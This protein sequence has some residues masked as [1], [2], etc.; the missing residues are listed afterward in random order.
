[1]SL[2]GVR[3]IVP[4]P[5][6]TPIL[7]FAIAILDL[8]DETRALVEE[9]RGSQRMEAIVL[10]LISQ[11]SKS[12]LI[13]SAHSTADVHTFITQHRFAYRTV[14]DVLSLF[15]RRTMLSLRVFGTDCSIVDRAI[16]TLILYLP[17]ESTESFHANTATAIKSDI[18]ELLDF[19]DEEQFAFLELPENRRSRV[20]FYQM[21]GQLISQEQRWHPKL[22]QFSAIVDAKLATLREAP[23]E[24]LAAGLLLDIRGLFLGVTTRYTYEDLFHWFHPGAVELLQ[25]AVLTFPA[26]QPLFLKFL[27][28]FVSNRK[29]RIMFEPHSANGLKMFKA[30]AG[31]LIHFF[32]TIDGASTAADNHRPVTDAIRIMEIIL[33]NQFSCIGA[34]EVYNDTTLT[35]LF[36]EFLRLARESDIA[37]LLAFPKTASALMKL[38]CCLFDL[39][40][41]QVVE[42]D[43]TFVTL[44]LNICAQANTSTGRSDVESSFAVISEITDFC[45]A[46]EGTEI[47]QRLW[48]HTRDVYNRILRMLEEMVFRYTQKIN[49]EVT[50]L[51]AS[52]LRMRPAAWPE[53]RH[54][55]SFFLRLCNNPEQRENIN[56]VIAIDFPE[57]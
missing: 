25:Q 6:S 21:M 12:F 40:L 33:T 48:E 56:A 35:D 31:A 5:E 29:S 57:G 19:E 46:M 3:L 52:V 38:L 20:K 34:L 45:V 54:R 11:C 42:I 28:E 8:V 27:V 36:V 9:G 15:F 41:A 49:Y 39:F 22:F 7:L 53:V 50:S 2:A 1:M 18:A 30:A 47:G 13:H 17:G 23:N 16:D 24:A 37:A 14:N 4:G 55:L 51:M 43:P 44:A 26:L 10:F 32:R